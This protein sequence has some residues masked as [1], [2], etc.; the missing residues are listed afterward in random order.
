M[1]CNVGNRYT[2]TGMSAAHVVFNFIYIIITERLNNYLEM[3][4]EYNWK[5]KT[6][7][8]AVELKDTIL[9]LSY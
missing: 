9:L 5:K 6:T 3:V 7:K 1:Y 4:T 2:Y 8:K